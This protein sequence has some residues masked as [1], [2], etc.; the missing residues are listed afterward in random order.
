MKWSPAV[1]ILDSAPGGGRLVR[2]VTELSGREAIERF[3]HVPLP[4][5]LE[6]EDEPLDRERYQTV[7]AAQ[8]GAVAAPTA[9]LHFS[10]DHHQHLEEGGIEN[11]AITLHVGPGTFQPVTEDDPAN[12]P[13]QE[14]QFE[15]LPHAAETISA[16]RREGRRIVAVARRSYELSRRLL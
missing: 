15:I 4:P 16:A 11:V 5:Y 7:Y 9:G 8:P 10:R 2:L 14:E 6:R 1:E 13:M 3:G 12:H